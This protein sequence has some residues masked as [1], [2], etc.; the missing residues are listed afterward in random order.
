MIQ[1]LEVIR[2]QKEAD[3]RQSTQEIPVLPIVNNGSG[4]ESDTAPAE[5]TQRNGDAR[6]QT[7]GEDSSR[8]N[9]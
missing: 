9:E 8:R 2:T 3:G 6:P 4:S 1:E 5:E 7:T